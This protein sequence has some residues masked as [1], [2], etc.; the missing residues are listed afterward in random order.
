MQPFEAQAAGGAGWAVKN[1]N[2]EDVFW[3]DRPQGGGAKT[4]C[5]GLWL[6]GQGR[7]APSSLRARDCHR[8][9]E[10]ARLGERL[11]LKPGRHCRRA[12]LEPANAVRPVQPP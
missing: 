9:A 1:P 7:I 12:Q 6:D 5:G 10:T 4:G 2:I 11:R 3:G 8:M